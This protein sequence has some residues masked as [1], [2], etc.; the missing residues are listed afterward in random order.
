MAIQLDLLQS[1]YGVS[2]SGAYFRI[3]NVN[4]LRTANMDFRFRVIIDLAAYATNPQNESLR[5]VDIRRYNCFI[6]EI[7]VQSGDTFLA[8]CYQW[9]MAQPDMVGAVAV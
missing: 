5:E 1:Q 9:V 4:I 7:E 8:R 3:V 6:S 2:F